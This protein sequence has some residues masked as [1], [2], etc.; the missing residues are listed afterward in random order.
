MQ[1]R[2]A[3]CPADCTDVVR[4]ENE[5][6]VY[7]AGTTEYNSPEE[8]TSGRE[9]LGMAM[10]AV[11]INPRGHLFGK[12]ERLSAF[13]AASPV[14]ASFRRFWMAPCLGLLAIAAYFSDEWEISYTDENLREI[15]FD[16]PC[17]L[18]C[19]S[20]MTAQAPRAYE[21]ADAFRE[22]GV[23]TVMGGIHAA[24]LPEEAALH[25]D[26]V[27]VGEGEVLFPRFLEDFRA[28]CCSR[29]YRE[30]KG[31]VRFSLEECITPR[32]DLISAYDYPLINVYTTR[33]C[34]RRCSFCCAS[35]VYGPVYRRKSNE[36]ILTELMSVQAMFADRLLLFADDNLLVKR[37]E[38]REL[39]QKMEVLGLRWIAQADISIAD[40]P[41]LLRLMSRA[42][43]QWVVVGLE[44]VLPAG[45][46]TVDPLNF[47]TRYVG[48]YRDKI[49]A[50]QDSG[51][52][53]YGTFIVG[54]DQDDKGIFE[55]TAD[56]ILENRLYGSNITVPTPLPGTELRLQLEREN[57]ILTHDWA[58][59]TLWDV[60]IR[61]KQMTVQELEE[62]LLRTYETVSAGDA[63]DTKIRG[64]FRAMRENRRKPENGTENEAGGHRRS[65]VKNNV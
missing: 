17:D 44:S 49:A 22:R 39:L 36:Q 48:K 46:G 1:T 29:I 24:L 6:K 58:F 64:M 57:R 61:P 63:A 37:R 23:T 50:I 5:K 31:G 11:L 2:G 18:V 60:V 16:E 4:A 8:K 15:N 7:A 35:N 56:F 43:C 42:G 28:G 45:L 14:M 47:K 59:Y 55:A 33:G 52:G 38:S 13:L 54:L 32:Y 21:I 30:G 3:G 40:D 19:L 20:A 65:E 53:V 62:G 41:S 51:I 12:N 34:P 26:V 9:R 25:A 27:L 10:K